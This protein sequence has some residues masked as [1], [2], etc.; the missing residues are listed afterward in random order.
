M[1]ESNVFLLTD[2]TIFIITDGHASV[3]LHIQQMSL[4]I[5]NSAGSARNGL[6]L[7]FCRMIAYSVVLH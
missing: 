3:A 7:Q 1:Y 2:R 4:N 6:K 5:S